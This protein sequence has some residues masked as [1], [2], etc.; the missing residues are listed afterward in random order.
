MGGVSAARGRSRVDGLCDRGQL[1]N[2][3]DWGERT[4]GEAGVTKRAT[5]DT[6]GKVVP[7]IAEAL[8]R[9]KNIA[10]VGSARFLMTTPPS[11][12]GKTPHT[13]EPAPAMELL[14]SM[15]AKT[16]HT[17]EPAAIDRS[18]TVP[19]IVGRAP[20]NALN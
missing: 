10:I 13:C 20:N 5:E 18:N 8:A 9:S 11:R 7:F 14:L 19:F 15:L 2:G 16:P 6:V 12:E 1:V 3:S 17:C 4:F